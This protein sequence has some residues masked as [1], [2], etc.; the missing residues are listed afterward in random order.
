MSDRQESHSQA[1]RKPAESRQ[2]E[3]VRTANDATREEARGVTG[4]PSDRQRVGK[5]NECRIGKRR[6]ADSAE[7][8]AQRTTRGEARKAG[9]G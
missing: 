9:V 1:A 2:R 7:A 6:K 4:N 5:I 3:G 8:R